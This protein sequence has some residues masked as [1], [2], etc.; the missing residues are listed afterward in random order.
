MRLFI[1]HDEH[2]RRRARPGRSPPPWP[3]RL[4]AVQPEMLTYY[5]R[6]LESLTID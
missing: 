4:G 2:L 5:P 3:R 1:S 6:D